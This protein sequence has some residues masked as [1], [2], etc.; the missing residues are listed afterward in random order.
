MKH[1]QKQDFLYLKSEE[2]PKVFTEINLIFSI[3]VAETDREKV[4]KAVTSSK[5]RYRGVFAML[6]KNRT[7]NYTIN[8]V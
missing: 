7:V 5:E 8:Y 2:H 4:E 1:C 6:Q 3:K